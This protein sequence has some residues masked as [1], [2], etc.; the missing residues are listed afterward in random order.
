MTSYGMPATYHFVCMHLDFTPLPG[1]L[2]S[3]QLST[4]YC[5]I[6]IP[7]H[8][9][10]LVVLVSDPVASQFRFICLGYSPS[11]TLRGMTLPPAPVLTFTGRHWFCQHNQLEGAQWKCFCFPRSFDVINHY[12]IWITSHIRVW[13]DKVYINFIIL[14]IGFFHLDH[15]SMSF[16]PMVLFSFLGLLVFPILFVERG[17]S[18]VL[19]LLVPNV[20]TLVALRVLCWTVGTFRCMVFG[21][22][23]TLA[24]WGSFLLVLS[25][26]ITCA[27]C[28][29]RFASSNNHVLCSMLNSIKALGCGEQLIGCSCR[30]CYSESVP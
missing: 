13:P 30:R 17:T 29:D 20:I 25:F 12:V 10:S 16:L 24:V 14:A 2:I 6:C 11:N 7:L 27:N 3:G 1:F 26:L 4:P 23:S 28:I 5:G 9:V 18:S 19:W 8:A 15:V 21:A 22:I